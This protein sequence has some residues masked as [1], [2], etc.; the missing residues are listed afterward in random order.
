M[1]A[2]DAPE[3]KAVIANVPSP[4]AWYGL[5]LHGTPTGSSWSRG[6]QPLPCVP[7]DAAAGQGVWRQIAGGHPVGFRDAYDAAARDR[8]TVERAFFPIERVA[9]PILCL[10]AG[11]DRVWNSPALAGATGTSWSTTAASRP[12]SRRRRGAS[13]RST[14]SWTTC[15]SAAWPLLLRSVQGHPS[16]AKRHVS[17]KSCE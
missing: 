16:A 6:K 11:D 4:F 8:S 9:G 5:G 7:E 17:W 10:A 12:R 14:A 13:A 15:A 1:V 3:V 2:A